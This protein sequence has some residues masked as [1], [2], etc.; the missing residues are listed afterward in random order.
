[1][2]LVITIDTRLHIW[3]VR[4]VFRYG[5]YCHLRRLALAPGLRGLRWCPTMRLFRCTGP[6][7][8]CHRG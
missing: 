2:D 3:Q 4:L 1:M 6:D 5:S 8:A 7:P